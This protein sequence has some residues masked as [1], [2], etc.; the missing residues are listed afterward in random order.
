MAASFDR[1]SVEATSASWWEPGKTVRPLY[2]SFCFTSIPAAV[3]RLFFRPD[4]AYTPPFSA[5]EA[6]RYDTVIVVVLDGFGWSL[7]ERSATRDVHLGRLL[8]EAVCS[9][10]TSCFPSTTTACMSSFFTGRSH[11]DTGMYEWTYYHQATGGIVCPL[12]YSHGEDAFNLKRRGTLAGPTRTFPLPLPE[13]P[14]YRRLATAGVTSYAFLPEAYADSPFSVAAL[15]GATVQPYGSLGHGLKELMELAALPNA[16]RRYLTFYYP[17]VDGLS[18]SYGPYSDEVG[19]SVSEFFAVF[20]AALEELPCNGNTLLLL[21]ADHGQTTVD[22][23]SV[24]FIDRDVPEVLPL[25]R[26][27]E[28]GSPFVPSGSP[29]DFFLYVEDDA[30]AEATSTLSRALAGAASVYRTNDLIESGLL[31]THSPSDA[32]LQSVGNVVILPDSGR[33]VF[34]YG[35]GRYHEK[36]PGLHGG[37]SPEEC[38]VPLL[39]LVR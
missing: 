37:L 20:M 26:R 6:R 15:T 22:P 36:T 4:E 12:L 1:R 8:D 25:L 29:R 39:A 35:D 16:R 28:S 19:A 18:H 9:K 34:W 38:T 11:L 33:G 31:G 2:D 3:E 30:V 13:G 14:I 7:F 5:I 32:F 23:G 10:L 17:A 27:G 24:V 21:T